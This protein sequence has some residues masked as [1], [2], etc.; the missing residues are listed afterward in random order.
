MKCRTARHLISEQLSRRLREDR[1][2][3]L[4]AHVQEC[5]ACRRLRVDMRRAVSA[6]QALPVDETGLGFWDRLRPRLPES[7]SRRWAWLPL[8]SPRRQAELAL[9]MAVAAATAIAMMLCKSPSGPLPQPQQSPNVYVLQCVEQ[10]A[11]YGGYQ[12]LGEE[13]ILVA[14]GSESH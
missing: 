8:F 12:S 9:P 7:P 6:L 10:H 3:S 2:E 4:E 14:N 5:G 1:K 13:V 11:T